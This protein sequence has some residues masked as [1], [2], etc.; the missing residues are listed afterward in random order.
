MLVADINNLNR[1][2]VSILT[3][4]FGGVYSQLVPLLQACGKAET[5]LQKDIS[6]ESCRPCGQEAENDRQKGTW[7]D[8]L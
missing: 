8:A 7:T 2:G 4:S 1:K 5:S 6:G 3:H